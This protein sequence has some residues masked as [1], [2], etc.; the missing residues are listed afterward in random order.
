MTAP[1]A[2][3][4]VNVELNYGDL[5]RE[6]A[7]R[8]IKSIKIAERAARKSFQRMEQDARTSAERTAR[9][10]ENAFESMDRA[11]TLAANRVKQLLRSI[12]EQ[13]NVRVHIQ[14]TGTNVTEL[15]AASQ[16]LRQL[17]QIGNVN[18]RA[19]ILL[20]GAS[21]MQLRNAADALQQLRQVGDVNSVVSVMM[22]GSA[23]LADIRALVQAVSK[24][25]NQGNVNL[26]ITATVHGIAE[27]ERL[28]AALRALPRSQDVRVNANT[29]QV[30]RMSQMLSRSGL[31]GSLT[32]LPSAVGSAV[33]AISK[34]VGIAG[35]ATV[36]VGGAMPA[37]AALAAA[38]GST[39]VAGAG[40]GAAGLAAVGLAAGTLAAGLG[41]LG[42][43]FSAMGKS[44]SGG[45][46][47]AA[48]TAKDIERAEYQLSRAVKDEGK[49]Q[50]DV[51]RARED[52]RK[53]LRDYDL[54][55]RGASLSERDAQL[56]LEDAR[57]ELAAGDF[58]NSRERARAVLRVDQ[59]EQ[60]LT[61]TQRDNSDL[62]QEAAEA[63]SKGVE[64]SDEVVDA[65]ERLADATHAVK[66]AQ[67]ALNE[68]R[69]PQASGG[70]GSD[71]F[72]EAMAKLSTNA[73]AFVRSI[74]AVQPAWDEMKKSV[75]DSLF[76][77]IAD[78]IGPLAD[79]Y[80]PRLGS[81][82]STVAD[83]F[84]EG[85]HS[86]LNFLNSTT[87]LSVMDTLLGNSSH[88]A[89]NFGS[90]LGN[91]V[92]GLAAIGAS[93]TSVFGPLTDGIASSA[94]GLSDMLVQAQQT[95][96]LDQF[97]QN[98]LTVARQ[99]GGVFSELGGI[100]SG[101]FRAASAAGGG[102]FLGGLTN[103]LASV[104]NW[105]N[106]PGQQALTSFFQSMQ[107]AMGAVLP[108]F[109]QVAGIIGGT[110]APAIAGLITQIAPAIS[111][112]I[113]GIGQGL[114]AIA[115]VMPILGNAIS[116]IAA[117]LTP[118]MPILGQLIAKIVEFAG[119][120]ISSLA[121]ALGPIIEAIGNG[122]IAAFTA[123]QPAIGP[124]SD[125][126]MTLSPII[127]QIATIL[128][129]VL[130]EA[131]KA[132]VPSISTIANVFGQVLTAIAPLLPILGDAL[133]QAIQILA[134]MIK[135]MAEAWTEVIPSLLQII[136]PL[137]EIVEALLPPLLEVIGAMLPLIPGLASAFL[138][139]IPA[140]MPLINILLQLVVWFAQLLGGILS[141]AATVLSTITNMVVGIITG[142]TNLITTVSGA[143]SGFVSDVVGFFVQLGKDAWN[144]AVSLWND[145]SK[146]FSDGVNTAVEWVTGIKDKV[147]NA[148]KDAGK[149][150]YDSGKTVVQGLIDGLKSMLGAIGDAIVKLFPSPIRSAVKSALGLFMGG[151]IPGYATGGTVGMA[152]G[153]FVVNARQSRR[154]SKLLKA[155][156]GRRISGAGTSTSDSITA[157]WQG[158]PVARVSNGEIGVPPQVA[159]PLMPLLVAI[160]SGAN[161]APFGMFAG[162]G[163]VGKEPYGLP[164][165]SSISYGAQ[166][167]PQWVYDVADRFGVK[168]STYPG[169]QEKSGKNKG[170]D[171]S[172]SV[173]NMQKFAE[174]LKSIAPDLEQ[175][176]WM[177]P[178][179][180]EQIGVAD[181]QL[182]GPGTSQPGYY[183]DDWA[184]HTDHVH[185]RQSYS[186]GGSD[187]AGTS[188][189][190]N[191]TPSTS[192]SGSSRTPIGSG[193]E[194]SSGS[195]TGSGSS[196]GAGGGSSSPSWGNSGG[197]SQYNS[198]ADAKRAGITPVW[199][200]NWPAMMGG[201]GVVAG[202][203]VDTPAGVTNT[204]TDST[205]PSNVD[206]IPLKRNPDGTYSSTDPA[207][208]HL[209]QR[210]SGGKADIVQQVQDANSGGNE[211]SGLFQIAKGTWAA[212][213]GTKYA[214]TAGE[215]TAEQQAEIAAAIF[216][217][218]GGSPWGAGLAGRESE[219][220][221]RKG[222]QRAGTPV[223]PQGN[224][225]V[226]VTNP[227]D[228]TGAP[229]TPTTPTAPS[230]PTTPTTPTVPTT[231]T[232]PTTPEPQADKMPYGPGRAN[233]WFLEHEWDSDALDWGGN[234]AKEIA[235]D[236][237]SP[238][239]LG[240]LAETG[241]D[242]V[243]KYL[244]Q[245]AEKPENTTIK[246]ADTVN[247]IGTAVE[248]AAENKA[249]MTAVLN[250]YRNG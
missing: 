49:A 188:K 164:V 143:I 81:A 250:T 68:A 105:V 128:G 80:I 56:D 145:V 106:G 224:V 107:A 237:L 53:K 91:L 55:L 152:P 191:D 9:H 242:E 62:A 248:N 175:V 231:P 35:L 59:A 147:V 220:E 71:P 144:A 190:I 129:Q 51:T 136:P 18:S 41:G 216:N 249:G 101:V 104:A 246:Y 239:G 98:A 77:G 25:D 60:R 182:V 10:W 84:N 67:D 93:S 6:L 27:V 214:P 119:P 11:A 21:V 61:E 173:S 187:T 79:N 236:W 172:G 183:R 153:T 168:P 240:G 83:G 123:L 5:D 192:S 200:E 34:F 193:I 19:N 154:N 171:W 110:I 36:A 228:N 160:N 38:L 102:N 94:R 88:M 234:A 89:A 114:A 202:A 204:G 133:V 74:Q 86:A 43:A 108:I 134:P 179:T 76:A 112:L 92:P 75:Q 118:V 115:P 47:A 95:G 127:A 24:L 217:K 103:S 132:L 90:A 66:E 219:D 82:M 46:G 33:G 167:F 163:S 194:G 109:L 139:L 141:F 3:A 57:A 23:S 126:F 203:T 50:K 180:G 197:G 2:E 70:G 159:G 185:T 30:S 213:G 73:Q 54:Q 218:S 223:T 124:I 113:G 205:T 215:A 184:G 7:V 64:G 230:T 14:Q 97:F 135:T 16:A 225:P 42:G 116:S 28:A 100:I 31:L 4:H 199:V 227:T 29:S 151:V 229:T 195:G 177:N 226:E 13:V 39:L 150:L 189:G 63:R 32:A 157:M 122:L 198:A 174:Y 158:R 125:L 22:G 201:A 17:Q 140:M 207:W 117:A 238:F 137:I 44:A 1:W 169:H 221:L 58:E 196:S 247:N 211:A 8:L 178:E 241:I 20:T 235:G 121:T 210:E 149:W 208:D 162:G 233:Q 245:I 181:G 87:G 209:M 131:I 156:G 243:V 146:A 37:V 232:T 72:A 176:I 12:P 15:R 52:A 212:N 130:A 155:I 142:F 96:K 99:L 161:L 165:G 85:A 148:F 120:I 65:Q 45:G 48:D 111:G 170:I 186:F 244:K 78:Q 222:I 26:V 69:N 40:A 138:K 166:G 206:T